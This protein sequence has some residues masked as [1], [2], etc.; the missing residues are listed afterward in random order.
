M[1]KKRLLNKK[2]SNRYFGII[3]QISQLYSEIDQLSSDEVK[4]KIERLY[5]ESKIIEIKEIEGNEKYFTITSGSK[6]Q[7]LRYAYLDSLSNKLLIKGIAE[8]NSNG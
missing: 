2:I 7:V 8:K 6:N 5:G 3:A 1:L 4:D